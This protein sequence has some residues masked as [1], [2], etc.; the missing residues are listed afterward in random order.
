MRI[1]DETILIG[2]QNRV[3]YSFSDSL[4]EIEDAIY[5]K[6]GCKVYLRDTAWERNDSGR[7]SI[8]KEL[9]DKNSATYS[10]SID[11]GIC[12]TSVVINKKTDGEIF[13]HKHSLVEFNGHLYNVCD[14][15]VD[16]CA[17]GTDLNPEDADTYK[18]RKV[19]YHVE[20]DRYLATNDF[21]RLVMLDTDIDPDTH[22]I[23]R[24]K[25]KYGSTIKRLTEAIKLDPDEWNYSNRGDAYYEMGE[26]ELA[27]ADYTSAINASEKSGGY[28][29]DIYISRG[30]AYREMGEYELSIADYSEAII[31][32]NTSIEAADFAKIVM[33]NHE[34]FSVLANDAEFAIDV[35]AKVIALDP[36][37]VHVYRYRGDALMKSGEY[38]LA[39]ADYA[40]ARKFDPELGEIIQKERRAL[41]C[42]SQSHCHRGIAYYEKGE[43]DLAIAVLTEATKLAPDF[44][45]AYIH[46]SKAYEKKGEY[47]LA[48]ADYYQLARCEEQARE[49]RTHEYF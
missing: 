49:Y 29:G 14:E 33:A 19:A 27:I 8:V 46:R 36:T 38:G 3:I 24:L 37:N 5:E 45:D 21:N 28:L 1:M 13:T 15:V 42:L 18:E 35:C 48:I 4:A 12:G 9:M 43:Y 16:M 30:K 22:Y 34:F 44:A 39:A 17:K 40:Q 11:N 31:E 41:K 32:D 6:T 7:A 26:Y 47:D 10:M 2:S 20:E 25:G 23:H